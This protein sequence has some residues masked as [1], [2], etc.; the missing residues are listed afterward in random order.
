MAAEIN[1]HTNEPDPAF[2]RLC[3]DTGVRLT[4]GSDA[5]DL[6]AIGEFTPHLQLLRNCGYDGDLADIVVTEASPIR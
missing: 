3:L 5:H 4:F 1:F 2:F 6:H